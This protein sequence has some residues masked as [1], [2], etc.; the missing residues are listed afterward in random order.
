[1]KSVFVDL[2]EIPDGKAQT[3]TDWVIQ[4]LA[5]KHI[6][7]ENVIGFCADTCNVMFGAHHS[8]S[9]LLVEKYPWIMPVKC[10]CHSIH[11]CASYTCKKL[12]KSLED[13]CR[14]I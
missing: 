14:K 4:S 11:L 2:V 7:M 12:P 6:P 9:K 10:F 13:L 5:E 1:M 3:I 8:V